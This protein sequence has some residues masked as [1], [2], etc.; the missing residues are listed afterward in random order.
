MRLGI[1]TAEPQHRLP[2][3]LRT[4]LAAHWRV[5]DPLDPVQIAWAVEG[6]RV[7]LGGVDRLMGALEQLQEPLGAVATRSAS[8]AWTPRPRATFVTRPG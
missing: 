6:L 8:P 3:E 5:D 4:S 1:V 7:Q 2:P